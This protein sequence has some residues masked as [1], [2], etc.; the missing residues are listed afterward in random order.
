ME[1]ARRDH[2]NMIDCKWNLLTW[3]PKDLT[4]KIQAWGLYLGL[5]NNGVQVNW[6]HTFKVLVIYDQFGFEF[7]CTIDTSEL[8]NFL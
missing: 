5:I 4:Q 6:A 8:D 2:T 7:E 3:L 1:G